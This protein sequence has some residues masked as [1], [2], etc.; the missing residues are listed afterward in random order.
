MSDRQRCVTADRPEAKTETCFRFAGAVAAPTIPSTAVRAYLK[1]F[2]CVAV[3]GYDDG[4]VSVS[5]DPFTP[6]HEPIA[7][8]W[9]VSSPVAALAIKARCE[10]DEHADVARAAAGLRIALTSNAAAIANAERAI[11]RM[12]TLVDAAQQQGLMKMLNARYRQERMRARQQGR[13]FPAYGVV[14]K[15]F[16]QSLLRIASGETPNKSLVEMALGV[17]SEATQPSARGRG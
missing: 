4:R 1:M 5:R 3:C 6:K 2:G 9:W 15:R 14:H 13:C 8:V 10:H 16:V 7:G 12:N 11:R 17:T